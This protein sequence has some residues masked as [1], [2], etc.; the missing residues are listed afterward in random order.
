MTMTTM[1]NISPTPIEPENTWI[2]ETQTLL[3]RGAPLT[4]DQRASVR[5]II[6]HESVTALPDRAF[7]YCTE[8]ESISLSSCQNLTSIGC[9]SLD[10]CRSLE[11]MEIPDSVQTIGPD[12]FQFCEQL[13][14][15]HLPDSLTEIPEGC[16][17]GCHTL[18]AIAVPEG[19]LSIG[20]LSFAECTALQEIVL[21]SSV[22]DIG[23]SAFFLCEHLDTVNLPENLQVIHEKAFRG[24]RSL[25]QVIIP[26]TVQHLGDRAFFH[27]S[28]AFQLQ[29]LNRS[30]LIRQKFRT[31]VRIAVMIEKLR[32]GTKDKIH[33]NEETLGTEDTT[34]MPTSSVSSAW[35]FSSLIQSVGNV[36]GL[37]PSSG[38]LSPDDEDQFDAAAL[39][40]LMEEERRMASQASQASF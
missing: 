40:S 21:P 32:A 4:K 27:C 13:Q 17:F 5:H 2:A 3:Y 20:R 11:L 31:K 26:E 36:I 30:S 1:T 24:C 9:G 35:N 18:Q 28:K 12:A 15:V 6:V 16:F 34:S 33:K 25:T 8:C 23:A 22:T 29:H 7:A 38:S 10:A 39:Q 37:E 14:A 19:C